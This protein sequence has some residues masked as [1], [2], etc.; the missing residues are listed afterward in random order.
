MHA[1]QNGRDFEVNLLVQSTCST[2][3]KED[4]SNYEEIPACNLKA[5]EAEAEAYEDFV[6][7]RPTYA[8]EKMI[9]PSTL[10]G[11]RKQISFEMS[12]CPIY[13]EH[14]LKTT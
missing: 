7:N 5:L 9:N 12:Q 10:G 3:P 2:H 11:L 4:E 1:C 6:P 13:R 8:N 14:K